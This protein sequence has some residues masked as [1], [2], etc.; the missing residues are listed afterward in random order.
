MR[1]PTSLIRVAGKAAMTI[2]KYAPQIMMGVGAVTSVAAVIETAKQAPK[3]QEIL[4]EHKEAVA[5]CKEALEIGDERY[6][7]TE[8]RKELAHTYLRTVGKLGKTFL[9]P[10]IMEATSLLCFFNAHRIMKERN[11]ILTAALASSVEAYN[12]Y[13]NKVIDAIGEEAEERIRLG[14]SEVVN[15]VVTTDEK[16][17]QKKSKEKLT[18][19]DP[20]N[21]D[22]IYDI[23]WMEGDPGYD[24]SDELRDLKVASVAN[25]F[26]TILFEKHL[27]NMVSLNDIRKQFK[28]EKEAQIPLGQIVGWDKDSDDGRIIL[29]TREV[30]VPNPENPK[31]FLNGTIISPN[32]SGSIVKEYIR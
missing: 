10:L 24:Q 29:R 9:M 28:K 13:R 20:N 3:A 26:N 32:I 18:V 17:K 4:E 2:K 25:Y 5:K 31:F 16:G 14:T 15:E 1:I 27:T 21:F 22:S 6:T 30:A 23:L 12:K 7:E 19:V 11:K 8:Y